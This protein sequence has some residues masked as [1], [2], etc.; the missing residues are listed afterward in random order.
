V[1]TSVQRPRPV[2]RSSGQLQDAT[3]TVDGQQIP[4]R[5]YTSEMVLP[6]GKKVGMGRGL[7]K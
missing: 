6:F 4:A 1:Q 5:A 7:P 2:G 3:M